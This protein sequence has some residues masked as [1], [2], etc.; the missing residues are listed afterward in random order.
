[1]VDYSHIYHVVESIL[2]GSCRNVS[3]NV[4]DVTAA[5]AEGASPKISPYHASTAPAAPLSAERMV[6]MGS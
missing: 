1:M 4:T 3:K 5:L 2:L 6:M